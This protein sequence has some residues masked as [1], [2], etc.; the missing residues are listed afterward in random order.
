MEAE[1]PENDVRHPGRHQNTPQQISAPS[2]CRALPSSRVPDRK[3]TAPA[4][5]SA[6]V[7]LITVTIG[8]ELGAPV[9]ATHV[10]LLSPPQIWVNFARR[11]SRGND[12]DDPVLTRRP[13]RLMRPR[14]ARTESARSVG[15]TRREVISM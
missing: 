1:P 13:Q 3:V 9:L 8:S 10:I 5:N 7:P 11:I 14:T 2:G 4:A 15:S 12:T 6:V